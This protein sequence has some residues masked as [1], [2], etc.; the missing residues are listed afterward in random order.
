M[1][2]TKEFEGQKA[3]SLIRGTEIWIAFDGDTS[4]NIRSGYY[5]WRLSHNN[6]IIMASSDLYVQYTDPEWINFQPT[7]YDQSEDSEEID[8]DDY[9]TGLFE[10]L[11]VHIDEKVAAANHILENAAIAAFEVNNLH[12]LTITFSNGALLQVHA[13]TNIDD[14]SDKSMR[15]YI[16][17][18]N[19]RKKDFIFL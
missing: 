17:K 14:A 15:N 7:E 4:L 19:G 10:V 2:Y 9:A 18:S 12:D 6:K 16:E 5:S 8:F 3:V 11:D 13:V 1:D